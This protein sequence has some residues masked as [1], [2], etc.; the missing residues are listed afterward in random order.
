MVRRSTSTGTTLITYIY[1]MECTLKTY[2]FSK[3]YIVLKKKHLLRHYINIYY[4]WTNYRVRGALDGICT[5]MLAGEAD[6]CCTVYPSVFVTHIV[7]STSC[8]ET[9]STSRRFPSYHTLVPPRFS[10]EIPFHTCFRHTC[11]HVIYR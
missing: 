8:A 7:V 11:T 4:V 2:Y 5:P 10:I 3:R 6:I 9:F 1:Y